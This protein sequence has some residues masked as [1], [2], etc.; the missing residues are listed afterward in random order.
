[1]ELIE[2]RE[3]QP[4]P[5]P[6]RGR[7]ERANALRI[8]P[9]RRPGPGA[10]PDPRL[11]AAPGAGHRFEPRRRGLHTWCDLCGDFVWGGGRKSLQCRHCSF[12][13][14]YR[15]RALVR[16]DCSGPPGAGDEDDGNEQVL[17]KDTNVD[18]PS[19]WEKTE[20]D[21]AQVEQRIKEYNSQ[22]N[23]NLFMSLNKDGS[24]AGFIKGT[25]KHLHIL[26]H[27]RASEVIDAL[28]RKFTV[29]DNPRK[30]ALFER[31]EKDEQ[32][33]LRKLGDDEQPLRLRLLAGPSEKVLSFILKENETGEVNWDAFTLPELH[34]FLLILQREEE[35]HVRRLRHRYACCRQKMQEALATRTPG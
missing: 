4:E 6:G 23:S 14:H 31:S 35:E 7:L 13:C 19:E 8:S 12:T 5:R 20:L 28:L 3:L 9:A 21:Q 18:E 16:L 34:N 26:S 15:C 2:L 1:M 32:V 33:Y 25:V 29:I 27:T 22:I 17:E 30:F 24:Y 11:T 10:H